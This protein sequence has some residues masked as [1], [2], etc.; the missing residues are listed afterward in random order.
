[1]IGRGP[2][3]GL[4]FVLVGTGGLFAGC[5]PST[6]VTVTVFAAASLRNAVDLAATAYT[7]SVPGIRFLVSADSSAALRV[8]IE[9]GAPADL[10]LSADAV[11]PARLVDDG[12]AD[13]APIAFA[14]AD[15]AIVV[16]AGNPAGI[17][18]PMD[19]ARAGT[20]IIAAGPEVPITAYADRLVA[21][22]AGLDGYPVD[23]A[24]RY[25][26]NVHSREDNARAVI[27][28]VELGEG[29]AGIV[30]EPDARASSA[31]WTIPLPDGVRIAATYAG[32]VVRGAGAAEAARAFLA[33]LAGPDGGSVLAGLGFER[34]GAVAIPAGA[35]MP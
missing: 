7:A 11:N 27:A 19:L 29:D 26:A 35:L 25:A 1:M 32:V 3:R 18:D 15:L 14:S 6:D 24:E 30:Y 9:Q 34:A 21:A 20:R 13:G 4:L 22:L 17:G 10:F 12:L 33:W 23:F 5:M 31:T 16:P 8:Q 2:A 28:K